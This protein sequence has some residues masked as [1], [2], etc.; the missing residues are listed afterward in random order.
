MCKNAPVKVL[1][2]VHRM[3]RGGMETRLMD[4]LRNIDYEKVSIDIFAYSM[5]PGD[6][7]GEVEKLGGKIYYNQT[8]TIKNMFWY[9]TYFKNFLNEHR[10]YR[11]V[12]AHQNA[13]CS[14]FCR[15]AYLAGVP[16]RIAH[17][18]TA[19]TTFS[20]EN[21][22]KNMIKYPTRYY[23]THYFAVSDL[24]GKWLFGNRLL[25]A[26]KVEVWKNAIDCSKYRFD[27]KQ[28]Q[29]ARTRFGVGSQHVLLHVGN[30]VKGKNQLFSVKIL[31][32][33]RKKEDAVLI[34][35]GGKG[36]GRNFEEVEKAVK[37]KGLEKYVLFL[38]SRNDVEKLL[39]AADVLCCPSL[40][41]G[42]PGAV[43]EAQAAGLPCVI[44]SSI[45]REA[46]VLKTTHAIDLKEPISE[47]VN[48]IIEA[49]YVKRRDTYEEMVRA[50]FDIKSLVEDLTK[51]YIHAGEKLCYTKK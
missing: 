37:E 13:W 27:L 26:G 51:F 50:G 40:F 44:S 35:A 12:H 20:I 14:V 39:M 41:E 38:G 11:I 6:F 4:I 24:A 2:V 42:M 49:F 23:A 16:V 47:W 18:R 33:I 19:I 25:K 48:A 29:E 3:G 9:V 1:A 8:L 15:G 17:S 5:E 28:R 34:F 22:A 43:L 30:F 32:E 7:D 46:V 21:T 45:T 10:E 31:E 36:D